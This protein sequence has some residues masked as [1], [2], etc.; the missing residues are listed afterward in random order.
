MVLLTFAPAAIAAATER[1]HFEA[2]GEQRT[3]MVDGRPYLVLG[4]QADV[5]AMQTH[6]GNA[7]RQFE[8]AASINC[9]TIEVPLRWAEVEPSMNA[10]TMDP[11]DWILDQDQ[12]TSG[13]SG[14]GARDHQSASDL[15]ESRPPAVQGKRL[16]APAHTRILRTKQLDAAPGDDQLTVGSNGDR[17][18]P[19]GAGETTIRSRGRGR[20]GRLPVRRCRH[21]ARNRHHECQGEE[22]VMPHRGRS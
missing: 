13:G 9:N 20:R 8:I 12:E 5:W 15:G 14:L 21:A 22:R 16:A 7:A 19:G 17:H 10:Y 3:L 4:A 6:D 2:R 1:P 11:V 18:V